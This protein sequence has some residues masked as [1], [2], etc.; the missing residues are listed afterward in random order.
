MFRT[1]Q[2]LKVK[3]NLEN[4]IY[5]IQFLENVNKQNGTNFIRFSNK[6]TKNN[7][8]MD[9]MNLYSQKVSLQKELAA[10]IRKAKNYY[11]NNYQVVT[12][13]IFK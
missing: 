2:I 6:I 5:W 1:N 7:G 11:N 12:N 13:P 4:V 8:C 10:K 3:K 9:L